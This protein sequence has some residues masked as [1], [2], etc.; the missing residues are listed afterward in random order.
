MQ[1]KRSH[2]D[3]DRLQKSGILQSLKLCLVL[4]NIQNSL[5]VSIFANYISRQGAESVLSPG[6]VHIQTCANSI[7]ANG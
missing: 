3:S 6:S 4:T 7:L 5:D 2:V 1:T